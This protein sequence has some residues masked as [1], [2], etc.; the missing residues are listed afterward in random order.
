MTR[1]EKRRAGYR[2]SSAEEN[3]L[4][5]RFSAV[6]F[7]RNQGL[8]ASRILSIGEFNRTGQGILPITLRSFSADES[9]KAPSK[10]ENNQIDI[11]FLGD[12]R[13]FLDQSAYSQLSS[14]PHRT[15]VF[16]IHV[17]FQKVQGPLA[18]Q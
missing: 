10:F 4:G 6:G 15:V 11:F 16:D 7:Q 5:D 12:R 3:P 18:Q 13:N 2:S 8:F 14:D 1:R 9:R 17:K